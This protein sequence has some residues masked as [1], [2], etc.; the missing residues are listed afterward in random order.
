MSVL[1]T[2][3]ARY[4]GLHVLGPLV[5]AVAGL[6]ASGNNYLLHLITAGAV[7]YVLTAAFNIIYGYA[8]IF[9]LALVAIYG[10]GAFASVYAENQWGFSFWLGL[11][12]AI[13]VTTAMCL[14][15]AGPVRRLN[16]LFIAI[17]TLSFA[18]AVG[19]SLKHWTT[20]SGGTIGIFSIKT[21]Q[22]FG[23]DLIGGYAP[24]YWLAAVA[25]WLAYELTLRIHKS[26]MRRKFLALREGPRVLASV[27]ISPA[28]TSLVAFGLSGALAGLAGAIYA[29]FQLVIDVS[30]FDFSRLT[31]LLL[32]TILGGAGFLQ[33]PFF[34]VVALVLMDEL[35]LATSQAGSLIY[36]VG[37]L[38]LIWLGSGGIA[39]LFASGWTQ[40]L[41]RVRVVMPLTSPPTVDSSGS[42]DTRPQIDVANATLNGR[43][44]QKTVLQVVGVSVSFGGTR[45]LQDV[46]IEL[47]SAEIVGLIGPNG[48]GKSSLLNVITGDIRADTGAVTLD[49]VHLLRRRQD[50]IVRMGIGRTFQS[51]HVIPDLTLL[52]NLC[53]AADSRGRAGWLRQSIHSPVSKRDDELGRL[54]GM[55]LLEEFGLGADAEKLAHDQ[56]YGALRRAEIARNLMLDPKLLLLDEPGAGLTEAERRELGRVIL[57]LK[58]RNHG[59]LL[60][61]HNLELIRSVCDRLYVLDGGQLIAHGA[62]ESV[63]ATDQVVSAYLGAPA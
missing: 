41:R 6:I 53:L 20:F 13:A 4:V 5:L 32:A 14:L 61:D 40:L 39:G 31:T 51:P 11:V 10:V 43:A 2:A 16:E 55:E 38:V 18:V 22:F 30:T 63:L 46:T 54:R 59:I 33:G 1:L 7:A 45:A 50:E 17:I 57:R 24:F 36:G 62:P 48:A 26:A 34:G 3:R 28:N 60:V 8:G 19:E 42:K 35:S 49:G 21:P 58:S 9:N 37:I 15:I 12:I 29:H 25:A 52:E 44:Q 47:N 27:G 23:R 56:P